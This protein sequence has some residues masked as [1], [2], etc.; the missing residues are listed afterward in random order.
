ME[1]GPWGSR[2][3]NDDRKKKTNFYGECW[4]CG[5]YHR[6]DRCE[7]RWRRQLANTVRRLVQVPRKGRFVDR[8]RGSRHVGAGE[9][10]EAAMASCSLDRGTAKTETEGGRCRRADV[11]SR[12]RR[13]EAKEIKTKEQARAKHRQETQA[14][15]GEQVW[16]SLVKYR[17]NLYFTLLRNRSKRC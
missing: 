8:E 14:E 15:G 3:G 2:G 17:D 13:G 6:S 4:S 10:A 1:G 9:E 7:S 16:L 12:R 11:C 5:G